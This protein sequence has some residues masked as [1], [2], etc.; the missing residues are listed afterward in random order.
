[1]TLVRNY[2]TV[3]LIVYTTGCLSLYSR[4]TIVFFYKY[5]TTAESGNTFLLFKCLISKTTFLY[6]IICESN[7][8]N[9]KYHYTYT[10]KTST[11]LVSRKKVS[12]SIQK[13]SDIRRK[14]YFDEGRPFY[15]Y[16]YMQ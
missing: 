12:K 14:K 3:R 16:L 5:E 1:M 6:H 7:Q 2:Y 15:P 9:N 4:K 8:E 11:K 10:L 13:Q